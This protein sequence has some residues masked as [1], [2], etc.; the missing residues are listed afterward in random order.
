MREQVTVLVLL[1]LQL[2]SSIFDV[3]SYRIPNKVVFPGMLAGL[4]LSGAGPRDL[5]AKLAFIIVFDILAI[6]F[7]MGGG[8]D[9]KLIMMTACFRGPMPAV[10]SAIAAIFMLLAVILAGDPDKLSF[11]M[12]TGRVL[13]DGK[14]YAFAPCIMA[15]TLLTEAVMLVCG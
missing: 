15:G 13:P 9:V 11:F 6:C 5:A 3:R 2:V 14:K 8:G 10:Y 12:A 1:S 7:P 4:V